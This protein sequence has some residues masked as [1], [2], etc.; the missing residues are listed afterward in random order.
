[1]LCELDVVR[2]GCCASWMLCE[3]DVVR[4]G[5]CA[6]WM[7]C[8]LDVV[9]EVTALRLVLLRRRRNDFR[10]GESRFTLKVNATSLKMNIWL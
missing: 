1:M 9:V 5:C 8:E 7:L 2:V 3:L 4:V 6:S 10:G